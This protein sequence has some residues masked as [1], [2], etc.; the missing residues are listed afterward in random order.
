MTP[1][2]R[3]AIYAVVPAIASVL[4]V[5]GVLLG[6]V[7]WLLVHAGINLRLR[8]ASAEAELCLVAPTATSTPFKCLMKR[9]HILF[10]WKAEQTELPCGTSTESPERVC[11]RHFRL[12]VSRCISTACNRAKFQCQVVRLTRICTTPIVSIVSKLNFMLE[13]MSRLTQRATRQLC[14]GFSPLFCMLRILKML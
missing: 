7:L 10:D 11:R 2:Q 3:T 9:I 8:Q 5:F 13:L 6:A 12:M 1:E 4:V 14:Q